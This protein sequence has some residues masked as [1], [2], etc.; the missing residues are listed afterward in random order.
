MSDAL[1]DVPDDAYLVPPA[2]EPEQLTRSERRRRL[3]EKRIRAGQHP[4]GYVP[5]HPEAA[6]ERGGP[7]LT[8]GTCR[9][10]VTVGHHDKTYP[11]CHL[12]TVIGDRTTYPRDTGCDSSDIRAWWPACRDWDGGDR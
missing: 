8:C 3:I 1:F 11:K 2:P 6:T 5:L 9:H 10:R 7:G 4:L 12:P